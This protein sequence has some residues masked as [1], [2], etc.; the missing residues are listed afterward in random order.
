MGVVLGNKGHPSSGLEITAQTHLH[1][2]I[3]PKV[4]SLWCFPGL[5]PASGIARLST[6]M[7]P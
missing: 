7:G 5:L 2:L 4:A 1:Q 3:Y 6:R